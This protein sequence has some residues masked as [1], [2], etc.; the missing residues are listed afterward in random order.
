M[1]VPT[2]RH[3]RKLHFAGYLA[4]GMGLLMFWFSLPKPLFSDPYSLVLEDRDGYL[5]NA[6]IA[7]DGQWRFPGG[8][9]VPEK[10]IACITSF[11][12]KRFFDHPGVDAKAL[13]RAIRHNMRSTGR[14]QGGS[15]LSM[16]VI[17]LSGKNPERNIFN[18]CKEAILALRLEISYSKKEIISLY[19]AH[20][21]FGSNVVGLE[22]ASWRYYGRSPEK[23]SWGEM[24]ALAVLP[25]APSLI[26]PGKNRDWLLAKRNRLIDDLLVQGYLD[27][28]DAEL[29]KMEPLP[30]KPHPLPQQ[31][32]HLLQR[33]RKESRDQGAQP[34]LQSTIKLGLQQQV[35]DIL[36][37]HHSSLK[38]Q[39]INNMCA[40]VLDVETGEALAYAGNI[41]QPNL[42]ELE[43]EVDIINAPRSPG[44]T[45]KPLLYAAALSDGIILPHALLPDIPMDINGYTPKNFDMNYDGAVPASK[46]LAR[47][48]NIP[49]VYL[50]R[51]YKYQR[52]HEW[53]KLSGIQTLTK[54]AGHYGL[55]LVLGG[56]EVTMWEL[57][58]VYASLARSLNHDAANKGEI[59][60]NDFHPPTYK[61]ADTRNRDSSK[62][63]APQVDAGSIYFSLMA[64]QEVMR[65]GEEALWEM[66][67]SSQSIA[68]KTGTSFGFRDAWA[69]GVSPE[70]IVAV[71]AGN[72]NG[73]GK[74]DLTGIK[75]A[76]PAMFD[77]FRLLPAV[78]TFQKPSTR[79]R[80]IPVCRTSGFR[81]GIDCGQADTL[82][83]PAM[84]ERSP[85]CPYH[86]IIHLD[87]NGSFR[88][89][90]GCYPTQEM[91]N[92]PW[93]T[94]PPAMEFYYK[95]L[96]AD[97]Q[98][99]PPYKEG[100]EQDDQQKPME[101]IYPRPGSRIFVPVEL[102]GEKGR[103]I[104]TATHRNPQSIVYWF[105]DDQYI[106]QTQMK[107]Q[108]ALN[109]VP[110]LHRL[111]LTDEQGFRVQTNFTVLD[112]E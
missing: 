105:L 99:M 61:Y 59:N 108:L 73:E 20:A 31:A 63:I 14:P 13:L 82:Y 103:T 76:A 67:S 77:I 55:S 112:K 109:P 33:F 29:S 22:A 101:L 44:S 88:V 25:N 27:A 49:A 89:H 87:A 75:S 58:G 96:N 50:L 16:Q 42:K 30:D 3:T 52:F 86:K 32:P 79:Y 43:S 53:L 19:A 8:H 60:A 7:P 64:M 40:L 1:S 72:A 54:P 81:A 90:A 106:G 18:K 69:I 36:F 41:Y 24:A 46:A 38:A 9:D 71:W 21:P 94:L 65:P 83:T 92:R 47:S 56:A 34:R 48:L 111:T 78:R 100:C 107:H 110:G 4:L 51:M 39:G 57:A 17:R 93:F 70:F 11:E 84:G 12:D 98:S 62:K 6:S 45:L 26:H 66:F 104:F 28:A 10:F 35:N 68:W 23:L 5:L 85:Q 2:I 95:K 15:T 91:Q 102:D 74:S 37:R 80:Y 97:Y